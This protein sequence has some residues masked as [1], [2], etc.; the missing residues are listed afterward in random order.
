MGSWRLP[1]Y[2]IPIAFPTEI[3]G[4]VLNVSSDPGPVFRLCQTWMRTLLNSMIS[5]I[6]K[7][8][9]NVAKRRGIDRCGF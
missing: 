3:L 7:T 6:F 2:F 8:V 9:P 4:T 1:R 5:E